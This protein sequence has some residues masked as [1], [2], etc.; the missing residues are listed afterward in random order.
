LCQTCLSF[1]NKK[2]QLEP[3]RFVKKV[4]KETV[5]RPVSRRTSLKDLLKSVAA[6]SR[7]PADILLRKG[8]L[9]NVV[10]APGPIHARSR[11]GPGYLASQV[12][13]FLACYPS[14]VSLALQR[15]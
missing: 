5:P 6:N 7:L 11:L 15:S 2:G 8:R 9:A 4:S 12:A 13:D 10:E 3:E 14:N 1:L